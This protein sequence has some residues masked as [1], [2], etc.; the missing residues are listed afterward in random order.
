MLRHKVLAIIVLL[1]IAGG[2]YVGL[3][4]LNGD[5]TAVR[6]TTATVE[7][8]TLIVSVSGSG[9]ASVS[10]RVDVTPDVSGKLANFYVTKDQVVQ[11]GQV[12]AVLDSSDAE[13]TIRDAQIA[14]DDAQY[15]LT[16]AQTD[17]KDIE[18]EASRTLANAYED[19]YD[20]VSTTFF[21]LAGYIDDLKDVLGTDKSAQEYITAYELVLGRN[22]SFTQKLLEDCEA[23]DD[24]F[25]ENFAFFRTVSREDPRDTIYQLISDTLETTK[26]ISQALESA[27]HMF[28]AICLY[29][30]QDLHNVVSQVAT[31]QSKV[32]SDVSA[33]YG[34]I[35]SLQSAKDTIDDTN[36]DTP[37]K[38]ETAQRS[39]Q[40]A[41]NTVVKKE[42]ALAD[43]KEELT[44]Y[45]VCTPFSGVIAAVGDVTMGETVLANTVLATLITKQKIAEITLNEVDAAKVRVGQKATITFDAVEDL[46]VTGKVT[47]VDTIGTTNQ[48]VVDYGVQISL[49]TTD[50]RIKPG[51]TLSAEI[52]TD[53]K[54]DVVMVPTTAIKKQGDAYYVQMVANDVFKN[55]TA[56]TASLAD[57]LSLSD[58]KSQT[59]EIGLANDTMTEITSGLLEDD[60]VV[61]TSS[62]GGNSSKTSGTTQTG[63]GGGGMQMLQM[64]IFR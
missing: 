3:R 24:L 62:S 47:E 46:T 23:A 49:D 17:Y 56:T 25:N 41:Q 36:K 13:K 59:V 21:K 9:Q 14:L 61:T 15:A 55:A 26:A 39:I 10:E 28:D 42:E 31:M 22:S 40:G 37:G 4:Q 63:S 35:T 51:M 20:T 29:D 2:G 60:I 57:A 58:L 7:K 5:G 53:V 52:I 45:S 38:L 18:T 19:G 30:Y 43:A 33:V 32:Q 50:E 6:Y 54:Q 12:L 11:N 34:N 16:E 27:R 48:G 44:K 1:A 64:E 8:G